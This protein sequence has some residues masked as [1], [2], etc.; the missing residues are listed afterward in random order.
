MAKWKC[1]ADLTS[2][3][4]CPNE[5]S[6]EK[7]ILVIP[8]RKME[9]TR[10][11]K[12]VP[13]KELAMSTWNKKLGPAFSQSHKVKLMRQKFTKKHLLYRIGSNI[14]MGFFAS[15]DSSENVCFVM[16]K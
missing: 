8:R 6:K 4:Q 2:N 10:D 13:G 16:S 7:K 3:C 5:T 15:N 12:K 14:E 9:D 11:E 1:G